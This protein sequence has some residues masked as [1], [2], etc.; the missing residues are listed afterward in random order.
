VTIAVFQFSGG[1]DRVQ[2][3]LGAFKSRSH[4]VPDML[5]GGIANTP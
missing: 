1:A 2:L 5:V 3:Q 4:A